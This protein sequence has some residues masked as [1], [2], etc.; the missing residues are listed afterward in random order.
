MNWSVV[1]AVAVSGAFGATARYLAHIWLRGLLGEGP[2]PIVALNV[3]GCLGFGWCWA[4]MNERVTPAVSAGVLIGFFGAFTT[5]SSFAF[6]GYQ[7]WD[8]RRFALLA[9]QLLIGNVVGVAALWGG[10]TLGGR[11]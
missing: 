3:V 6:D 2:W 4:L 5:F 10:L 9:L 1:L 11:T 7:L 8:Q